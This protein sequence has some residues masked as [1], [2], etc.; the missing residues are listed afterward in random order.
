L[1][2]ERIDLEKTIMSELERGDH[3]D[4][5]EDEG[6]LLGANLYISV[7]K[8]RKLNMKIPVDDQM[9][10]SIEVGDI[11]LSTEPVYYDSGFAL[12]P[13]ERFA[14]PVYDVK[15][16]AWISVYTRNKKGETQ[17]IGDFNVILS[18]LDDQNIHKRYYKVYAGDKPICEVLLNVLFIHNQSQYENQKL[19]RRKETYRSTSKRN[20]VLLKLL[21]DKLDRL[22]NS[23]DIQLFEELFSKD[24][25]LPQF[26]TPQNVISPRFRTRTEEADDADYISE[27][28]SIYDPEN[29]VR[30]FLTSTDE[31][32][33]VFQK[34]IENHESP[35]GSMVIENTSTSKFDFPNSPDYMKLSIFDNPTADL[36]GIRV[37]SPGHQRSKT[38]SSNPLVT[39]HPRKR[40]IDF[41]APRESVEA[42]S[43]MGFSSLSDIDIQGYTSNE[44][45]SV[46]S[47]SKQGGVHQLNLSEIKTSARSNTSP[48]KHFTFARRE[49]ELPSV[50]TEESTMLR[51]N[52]GNLTKRSSQPTSEKTLMNKQKFLEN[53]F[54]IGLAELMKQQKVM[55]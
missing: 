32:R 36:D 55:T 47:Q 20:K 14:I 46:S 39:K 35:T 25:E 1:L 50:V 41:G 42:E 43:F 15:Q 28:A 53:A 23:R 44:R 2:R 54:L 21:Q 30:V 52:R 5:S 12:W 38:V 33:I 13:N 51:S 8:I 27:A 9:T 22:K 10:V 48:Q 17:K 7:L 16:D 29:Q 4:D 6:T 11:E 34:Y 31:E 49:Q 26:L 40:T 24:I 45:N 37:A 19:K 18:S 3:G